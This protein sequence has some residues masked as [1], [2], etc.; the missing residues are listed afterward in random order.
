MISGPNPPP[1]RAVLTP[2]LAN[3]PKMLQGN[4]DVAKFRAI[5]SDLFAAPQKQVV[6]TQRKLRSALRINAVP[7]TFL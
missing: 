7:R 1:P 2:V 4:R 6:A 3:N 5:F